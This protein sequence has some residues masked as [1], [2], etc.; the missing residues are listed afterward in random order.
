MCLISVKP[1]RLANPR[2]VIAVFYV[3]FPVACI[4]R[5]LNDWL[6]AGISYQG[7]YSETMSELQALHTYRSVLCLVKSADRLSRGDYLG[8]EV[9]SWWRLILILQQFDLIPITFENKNS[10]VNTAE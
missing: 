8:N 4:L 5:E 6:E 7:T 1:D 3:K 10:A 2:Q 9:I